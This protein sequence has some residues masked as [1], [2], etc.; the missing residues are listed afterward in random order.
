MNFY[1]LV[2]NFPVNVFFHI[3]L[4]ILVVYGRA[5]DAMYNDKKYVETFHSS[6]LLDKEV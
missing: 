1:V 6:L 3:I 2:S 4:P 5:E